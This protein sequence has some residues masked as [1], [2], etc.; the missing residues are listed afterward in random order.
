MCDQID[1]ILYINLD[2]RE[3]RRNEIEAEIERMKLNDQAERF[4]AI[5]VLPP[6][7]ILGC[8]KSH[9]AVLKMA[10]ER[11]YKRVLILEDDFL[12]TVT[13]EELEASLTNLF[14]QHPRFDVCFLTCYLNE[15][16]VLENTPQFTKVHSATTASAYIVQEH[17]YDEIIRL[18]EWAMPQL[19]ATHAHWLYA[20]DQVWGDLQKRDQWICF[21]NRL[22]Q[23]R[24][25][26][27]DNTQSFVD[28]GV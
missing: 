23:Q 20:N 12:F 15:G 26:F 27:S 3:D 21:T 24:P 2:R 10:K 8:G 25:G 9:L 1:R 4:T 28:R 22:G 17:Y 7:G 14:E 16:T 18:Y 13:R 5:E 6:M 11:A 19:E